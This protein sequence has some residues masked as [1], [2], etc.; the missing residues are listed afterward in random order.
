MQGELTKPSVN[1]STRFRP[2]N[3]SGSFLSSLRSTPTQNDMLSSKIA[4]NNYTRILAIMVIGSGVALTNAKAATDSVV[5]KPFGK[6]EEGQKVELYTLTNKNGLQVSLATYGAM[7]VDLL[8]PD[9]AGK[10]ADVSLGY[11]T[12]KPYFT[13]CPYFGCIA[14][15]YANRIAKGKFTLDGKTYKLATNDGPNH[16]HGGVKGF[17][18]QVWQGQIVK[19]TQPTV[20]FTLHSPDGQEGYP[21]NLV[22]K[23]T[24][25]LTDRNQLRIS[26]EAT[27]DK[28]TIINLTNHTYFNLAGA[29]NGSVLDHELKI[30]ADRFTPVDKTL[31]PTGELK[32]VKGTPMDFRKPTAIGARIK[33]VGGKPVGYD[34]NYVLNKCP[35]TKQCIAA[36]VFE[37]KSGRVMKVSTD[38]PGIQF[39]SGNFLDGTLTGKGGKVYK[40]Y[41]GFCLETQHFPDSP[42]QPKFPSTV[43]R[44]GQTYKTTTVYS[45]SAK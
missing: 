6:T 9:R 18:K 29:G 45:F 16:L 42:N 14:G 22:A 28:P 40:Q 20:R 26:Y 24:Y 30:N 4:L 37:P 5:V 2:Y 32:A 10:L 34:H 17:D 36:E 11:K 39:Y 7:V 41:H 38:Q 8:V 12:L 15:R 3:S 27:T 21:G 35:L 13:K 19:A 31:I 25:T 43:L 1:E 44:P 23:V 33:E